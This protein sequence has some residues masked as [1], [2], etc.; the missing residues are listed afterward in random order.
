M[1]YAAFI[2]CGHVA[3]EKHKSG[4]NY[5]VV[6]L[7]ILGNVFLSD[8]LPLCTVKIPFVST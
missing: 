7:G 8:L 5:V 6:M 2:S 1:S 3:I 4:K